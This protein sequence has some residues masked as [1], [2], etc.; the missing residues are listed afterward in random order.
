M[1]PARSAFNA[2]DGGLVDAVF[3]GDH[4][5][6]S[7]VRTYGYHLGVGQF[8]Q[9]V[10]LARLTGAVK[11]LVR[12]VGNARGPTEV[13]GGAVHAVAIV[14]R[15]LH[16]IRAWAKERLSDQRVNVIGLLNTIHR[17]VQTKVSALFVSERRPNA[18]WN[19]SRPASARFADTRLTAHSAQVADREKPLKANHWFPDFIHAGEHAMTMQ[20]LQRKGYGAAKNRFV[21]G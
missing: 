20:Q 4:S 16:S 15:A 12:I 1:T 2:T 5:L 13:R 18:P 14:V 10:T 8:R 9:P 19:T 3:S 17:Q 11:T 6:K 7:Q 21:A